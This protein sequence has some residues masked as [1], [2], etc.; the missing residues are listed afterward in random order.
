MSQRRC[1]APTYPAHG[2][3]VTYVFVSMDVFKHASL[4]VEAVVSSLS[5][6]LEL[7]DGG[8][9]GPVWADPVHRGRDS[10]AEPGLDGPYFAVDL[11]E[12]GLHVLI[13]GRLRRPDARV[14]GV[15]RW[16]RLGAGFQRAAVSHRGTRRDKRP[17]KRS[18]RRRVDRWQQLRGMPQNRGAEG[19]GIFS[20][21]CKTTGR[22][23]E[24]HQQPG[25]KWTRGGIG[26]YQTVGRWRC[27][28]EL[29]KN[30][31]SILLAVVS[32]LAGL[33]TTK[34][35]N[36]AADIEFVYEPLPR[37]ARKS[38]LHV[39]PEYGKVI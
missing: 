5:V 21:T 34:C 11:E 20:A 39:V 7:L 26:S 30:V 19:G 32:S 12:D 10:L 23:S 3:Y 16:L 4:L 1:Y 2:R 24:E 27:Y 38:S 18:Q 36:L 35:P 25:R 13:H 8:G 28:W 14:R 6:G 22:T 29:C 17:K 33:L 37:R 15:T 31:L 9:G